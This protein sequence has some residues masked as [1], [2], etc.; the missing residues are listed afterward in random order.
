M[1]KQTLTPEKKEFQKLKRFVQKRAPG[2][3]T[4]M[5]SDG[6]FALLDGQGEYVISNSL[7]LPPARSVW[8][9]WEQAKYALWYSNMI[10]K[11]NAA[12]CEEKIWKKLS[13]EHGSGE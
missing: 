1:K 4:V 7:M 6:S 13:K 2:A 11:S 8:Q 3:R 5:E 10:R 12:F 9:A